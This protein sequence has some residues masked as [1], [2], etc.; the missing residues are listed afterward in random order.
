MN[1]YNIPGNE[2]IE[3]ILSSQN[4][5]TIQKQN[6]LFCR[7]VTN[8]AIEKNSKCFP[9]KKDSKRPV[10]DRVMHL[11]RKNVMFA[12]NLITFTFVLSLLPLRSLCCVEQ[13]N[14]CTFASIA[15]VMVTLSRIVHLK[16]SVAHATSHTIA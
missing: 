12:S 8:E 16:Q 4:P 6:Y 5:R 11:L 1:A 3:Y 9:K 2:D 13:P 7:R 14:N 15:S 10:T